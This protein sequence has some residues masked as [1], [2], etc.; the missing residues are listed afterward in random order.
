MKNDQIT[1]KITKI[2]EEFKIENNSIKKMMMIH[3]YIDMRLPG[4]TPGVS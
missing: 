3:K 4:L 2:T 1:E